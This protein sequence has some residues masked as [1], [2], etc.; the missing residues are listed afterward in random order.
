MKS[1]FDLK[2]PVEDSKFSCFPGDIPYVIGKDGNRYLFIHENLMAYLNTRNQREEKVVIWETKE[3]T[4]IINLPRASRF[5]GKFFIYNTNLKI[6]P[7]AVSIMDEG[8]RGIVGLRNF[9][10]FNIWYANRN[11]Y[12]FGDINFTNNIEERLIKYHPGNIFSSPEKLI[13][14]RRNKIPHDDIFTYLKTLY[15]V[16]RRYPKNFNPDER[17]KHDQDAK[18]IETIPHDFPTKEY[19]EIP[20]VHSS[21]TPHL[22][23]RKLL[24]SEIEFLTLMGC[25]KK[26]TLI[27]Y[28]GAAKGYHI[29][30]LSY[31]FP[32]CLFVLYD[33]E[34]FGIQPSNTIIIRRELFTNDLID[35]YGSRCLLISDIRSTPASDVPKEKYKMEF[36]K[37]VI[38]D[39]DLQK[40]WALNPLVDAALLKFRLPFIEG[41]TSY[42]NGE[43]LIQP[44]AK[45]TSTERR[46][47]YDKKKAPKEEMV[48]NHK[49]Y[50]EQSFY[51]NTVYR[52]LSFEH[53]HKYFGRSYDSLRESE[54]LRK[55][56][57]SIYSSKAGKELEDDEIFTL[58][59]LIDEYLGRAVN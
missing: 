5:R 48:I 58:S 54:I 41:E 37:R 33:S 25:S 51:F 18:Y 26:G 57:R 8:R 49:M 11:R 59:M 16:P 47:L 2:D 7:Y 32:K 23:Q 40:E 9:S 50:E 22:G 38:K 55:Y 52:K 4:T 46:L 20:D 56:L 6:E 45:E 42:L 39:M 31:L 35:Q 44:W 10:Y 21:I 14:F 27:H 19:Q 17:I 28:A 13:P 53:I 36:E 15:R 43:I 1:E 29:P 30:I 3:E 12:N 24:L 34:S